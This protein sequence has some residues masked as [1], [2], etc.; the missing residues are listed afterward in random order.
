MV[1]TISSPFYL[2]EEGGQIIFT[3]CPMSKIRLKATIVQIKEAS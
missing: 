3:T 2:I 1:K